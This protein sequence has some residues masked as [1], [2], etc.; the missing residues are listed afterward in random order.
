MYP[1]TDVALTL[2]QALTVV[3]RGQV[4]DGAVFQVAVQ[5]RAH[6]AAALGRGRHVPATC[7]V[8]ERADVVFPA[9]LLEEQSGHFLN[10]EQRH[11]R[12]RIV[13]KATVSPMTDLRILAALTDALG[14]DLGFRAAK[15]AYTDLVELGDWDGARAVAPHEAVAAPGEG[16]RV[17]GWRELLDASQGNDFEVALRATARPVVAR[18]SAATAESLGLTEV[19][20]VTAG[21]VTQLLPVEI[22]AGMVDDVVWVPLN[23]GNAER[24][25]VVGGSAVTVSAVIVDE[26]E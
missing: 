9:A 5:C 17:A 23:P 15:Q 22:V 3:L 13:N 25:P 24:L 21:G 7:A 8:T 12:V 20:S 11:G 26:G 10:W 1:A 6:E 16:L 19:A 2:L 14:S 18:F 4:G